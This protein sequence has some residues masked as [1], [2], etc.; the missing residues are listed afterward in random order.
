MVVLFAV[1]VADF[2]VQ[3]N[4]RLKKDR[5]VGLAEVTVARFR[6][7]DDELFDCV[8]DGE[9]CDKKM[10]SIISTE[11][12]TIMLTVVKA[13]VLSLVLLFFGSGLCT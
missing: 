10:T 6:L 9:Y 11:T 3:Q 8:E 7:L 13:V 5:R 2:E 12:V 4:N 1:A